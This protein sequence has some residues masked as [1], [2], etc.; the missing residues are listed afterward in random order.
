MAPGEASSVRGG[1]ENESCFSYCSS[2]RNGQIEVP[3]P[4]SCRC[5]STITSA[6]LQPGVDG[7]VQ[8]VAQ[9]SDTGAEYSNSPCFPT[10]YNHRVGDLTQPT[11]FVV[12]SKQ[13]LIPVVMSV[14]VQRGWHSVL[15]SRSPLRLSAMIA[16]VR[17]SDRLGVMG[18]ALVR[19]RSVESKELCCR[20]SL[21]W[22]PHLQ[23][24]G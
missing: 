8:H 21:L 10:V 17:S 5:A 3:H 22:H 16:C 23:K 1:A 20:R 9:S 18:A 7:V 19:P 24:N 11:P 2:H 4:E 15:L 12:S 13:I 6:S 14:C